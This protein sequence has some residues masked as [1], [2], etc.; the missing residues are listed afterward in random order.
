MPPKRTP[1]KP[2]HPPTPS[3][4]RRQL[5]YQSQDSSQD[6]EPP[7]DLEDEATLTALAA[8]VAALLARQTAAAAPSAPRASPD[9]PGP[10][11][12]AQVLAPPPPPSAPQLPP[13]AEPINAE[14]TAY[15]SEQRL[16]NAT[17]SRRDQE[18]LR[19]LLLACQR[20][21]ADLA[22]RRFLRDRLQ[23]YVVVAHRGWPA[24]LSALPGWELAQL[25][26]E[27]PPP[28][29]TVQVVAP[30]GYPQQHAPPGPSRR[31]TRKK[32]TAAKGGTD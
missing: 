1:Q 24:A 28:A 12:S 20:P 21:P 14:W 22:D 26:V 15:L 5:T 4:S 9:T 23:L 10:S 16:T 19:T 25:G 27:L 18:E 3:T 2:S 11:H 17:F 32:A 30:S 7:P 6:E 8:K 31:R 29:P 13:M